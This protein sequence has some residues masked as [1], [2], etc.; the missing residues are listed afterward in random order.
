MKTFKSPAT[1]LF[2]LSFG[3][4]SVWSMS[5]GIYYEAYEVNLT[6]LEGI[7][8]NEFS[9]T[10][11]GL[12]DQI[13]IDPRTSDRA[14]ALRFLSTVYIPTSGTWT[15]HLSSDDG[16]RLYLDGSTTPTVDN[17]GK[18]RLKT[19]SNTVQLNAGY[20]PIEVLYF[21]NEVGA[22]ELRLEYEGPGV[23]RQEMP[24]DD[25]FNFF[26][27]GVSTYTYDTDLS[28]AV[29]VDSQSDPINLTF[30]GTS[31]RINFANQS[32]EI[33]AYSSTTTFFV[34]YI[35]IPSSGI[36]NFYLGSEGGSRL[37]LNDDPTPLIES[38]GFSGWRNL[39]ASVEIDTPSFYRIEVEYYNVP[40][41]GRLQLEFEGPGVDRQE[42]SE[43]DLFTLPESLN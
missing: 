10:A 9:P 33:S 39:S 7:D 31:D 14:F 19:E 2:L 21:Q 22:S 34:G 28:S 41:A 3:L 20:Y 43:N 40:G 36:W 27:K 16:S 42:I 17:D 38:T 37:Y 15:F 11:V 4:S 30:T 12:A 29:L 5:R 24:Q 26:E 35:N 32:S 1:I 6:Q 25:F 23:E 18:H 13:N 8:F